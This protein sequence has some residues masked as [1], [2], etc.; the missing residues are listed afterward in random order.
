VSRPSAAVASK[1]RMKLEADRLFGAQVRGRGIC[2][3]F[4]FDGISC[5]MSLQCAHLVPR[6]YLSVR[7]DPD[8]AASLCGAHHVYLTH[9]PLAHDR[10]CRQFLGAEHYEALKFRAEQHHGSPDYEEILYRLKGGDAEANLALASPTRRT[11]M[12]KTLTFGLLLIAAAFTI[13]TYVEPIEANE[14]TKQERMRERQCRY[15][16]LQEGTWTAEEERRTTSCVLGRW[17]VPGGRATFD[18]VISCES[19]WNR[20]A[21]NPTGPYVG[22]GQHAMSSW[23][24]RVRSYSPPAWNLPGSWKNSRTMITVTARMMHSVG[25]SPWSCA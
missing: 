7:W 5:S 24:G 6:R 18:R 12:L 13:K 11:T 4:G 16:W 21:F 22:L 9:F 15:Q 20:L 3:A 25:L 23:A 19:G 10:F 1:K 8:N 2:Q 14:P 17:T